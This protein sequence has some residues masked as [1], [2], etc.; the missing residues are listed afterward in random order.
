MPITFPIAPRPITREEFTEL[1]YRITRL[2]YDSHNALGRLCDEEIYQSD[3]AARI[4]AAGLGPVRKEM[5]IT[6]SHRDFAKF[7]FLD[8]VACDAAIYELKTST[9]LVTEHENQLLNYLFLWGAQHGKLLNFRP[10]QVETRFVNTK[11]TPESRKRFEINLDRWQEFNETSETL[12]KIFVALLEDWGAF[13]DFALYTEAIT[14]FFGGESAVSRMVPLNR[15]GVALG[16][17]RMHLLNAESAFRVTAMTKGSAQFENQLN[18]LLRLTPI[19]NL[20]WINLNHHQ[21]EFV[22]LRK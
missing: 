17:Q 11:L 1:D 21:I 2:A 8:M 9:R 5:T 12:R 14:H 10:V 3:L 22:T 20:Y 7:Y 4:E 15:E 18:S 16:N 13:L 6:V 19:K